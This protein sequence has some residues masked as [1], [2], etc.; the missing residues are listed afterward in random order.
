MAKISDFVS[1]SPYDADYIEIEN[2][3]GKTVTLLDAEPFDN[4]KGQGVHALISMEGK[5]YRICSHG[6]AVTET[7]SKAELLDALKN[8]DYITCKFVKVPS[9]TNPQNRVIKLVDADEEE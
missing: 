7:L 2:I 8:G 6:V 4:H 1:A 3:L 9:K 5:E